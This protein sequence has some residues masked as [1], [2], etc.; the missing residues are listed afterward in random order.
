[1]PEVSDAAVLGG[2][3]G[4]LIDGLVGAGVRNFCVCPGSRSTPLALTVVQHPAARVWMHVDERS[5]GFFGLGLAKLRREPVALICTSGTA[6]ANFFPAVVEASYARVPLIVL[7]ADR[8]HELRDRGAAQTIDQIRL[9]GT[10]AKWFVD[11][12]EPA[13]DPT[14]LSYVR[15]VASRAVSTAQL[16]PAGPV[17]LN[18]PFREPLIPE[19][20]RGFG[21]W[22]LGVGGTGAGPNPLAPFPTREGGKS[23]FPPPLGEG[24]GEGE[25]ASSLP[26]H[27]TPS[28]QHPRVASGSRTP[29]PGLVSALAEELRSL[30]RGLIVCGPQD[31]LGLAEPVADL[32]AALGYPILADPLSGVRCGPHDRSRVLDR[33]DGFL[34]DAEFVNRHAPEVVLRFGALPT[35]KPVLQFLQKYPVR[36]I[37]VDGDAG[38]N[39]PAL[40][41]TDVVQVEAR[42]F[43]RLLADALA[44]RS[45]SSSPGA[46]NSPWL[47]AWLE[48]NERSDAA[49]TRQVA[50][51]GELFEGRVFAELAELLPDGATVYAGNSMPVR[52]LDTFFPASCRGIRF[53]ANRGVNGIDGVV[54]SALGASAGT[55]GPLVLVIGD[56][57]F[58][59]DLNGLLAAKLHQ[60]RATIVLINNDGGGIFSFL[61]QAEHPEHF[62]MLFGT[63]IGLNFRAPVEMYGGRFRRVGSWEEFRAALRN[64][65][66]SPGL[67]VVEVPTDRA[68]NVVLHRATWRAISATLREVAGPAK[69]A[70][71][72]NR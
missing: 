71:E 16:G 59:H 65:L 62:E 45:S 5:A 49:I 2:F 35:S 52:D 63:P 15:A 40:T 42:L 28:T 27:P 51:T 72:G 18:C 70:G 50:T 53:L 47:A 55:E 14:L 1:M 30:P 39:D 25:G 4:T 13:L 48:A 67:D 11:L 54:S 64:S 43:C 37:L 17:H 38:W 33:Y 22:V 34:R 20:G 12:P 19:M 32:A 24:E 68:R 69:L 21:D 10:H 8:P 58:Y 66:E 31:D 7:T 41:A 56:L 44:D 60:L 3:V 9:Y 61:P 23:S 36:Q 29:S 6:A 46:V 57:S 26:Q